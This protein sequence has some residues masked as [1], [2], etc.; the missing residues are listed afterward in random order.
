MRIS[1]RAP[2]PSE[3]SR[4]PPTDLS[5]HG[6]LAAH[7]VA[8][9]FVARREARGAVVSVRLRRGDAA[10]DDAVRVGFSLDDILITHL[11][12]D[13]Y[14]GLAGLLRTMSLQGRE[15]PLR[16]W[17]PHGAGETLRAF[18]DLGGDRLAF[19]A[20]VHELR[21]GDAIEGAGFGWRRSRRTTRGA[22]W[23]T[24][25]SKMTAPEG[26]TSRPP[27]NWGSRKVRSSA[28][29]T[30]AR[31]WNSRTVVAFSPM[32]S[33]VRRGRGGGWCTPAIRV[34]LPPRFESRGARTCWCTRRR[35]RRTNA[36]GRGRPA[37]PRPRVPRGVAREAGVRRLVLTHVS[38]RYAEGPSQL[39]EEARAVF[40]RAELARDGWSADVPFDDGDPGGADS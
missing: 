34:P 22:R 11:H 26:S 24:P 33:W 3:E 5:R 28:D 8:E 29:S 36:T 4:H 20:A 18:R 14:L 15:N 13:H 35:S 38:A 2:A 7:S 37:T 19:A 39:L 16:I 10:A 1:S 6:F 25:S 30:V 9:R 12:S 32:I 40:P 31:A 23:G 21:A 17:A 27:A